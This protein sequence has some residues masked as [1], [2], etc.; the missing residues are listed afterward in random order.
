VQPVAAQR[1][2]PRSAFSP[3]RDDA[4]VE[5][6]SEVLRHRGPAHGHPVGEIGDPLLA[7]S[8]ALENLT[9]Q[10]P[11]VQP[12]VVDGLSRRGPRGVVPGAL[13]GRGPRGVVTGGLYRGNKQEKIAAKSPYRCVLSVGAFAALVSA[14]QC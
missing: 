14:Q 10:G 8:Q 4:D 11:E 5:H 3:L 13:Y 2:I 9:S 12:R 6:E 1:V 7:A